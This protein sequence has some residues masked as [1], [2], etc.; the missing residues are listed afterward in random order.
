MLE[1]TASTLGGKSLWLISAE[2]Y[3]LAFER[4]NLYDCSSAHR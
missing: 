4:R 2:T 1:L 3:A